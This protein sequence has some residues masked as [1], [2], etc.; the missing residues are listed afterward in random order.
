MDK[1]YYKDY[2]N[3][4]RKH[5]WFRARE[6]IIIDALKRKIDITKPLNILNVGCATGRSSEYLSVFGKVTSVEYDKDCC[7]FL[8]KET[9]IKPINASATA[10]P[11]IDE[12]FDLVCAFDVIEHIDEHQL[13]AKEICRVVKNNGYL[14]ITV[15]AYMSLW[16]KHDVINHHY[17]RYK[18]R[19]L[20]A[21]FKNIQN[22]HITHYTYFNTLFF[23]LIWLARKLS[24]II[25][26]N[27]KIATSDFNDPE[28]NKISDFVLYRI[29]LME[30]FLLRYFKFPFGVSAMLIAKKTN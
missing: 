23:P 30:K 27:Q 21:L 6:A 20:N 28:K 26:K 29:F 4:E 1:N 2:Y 5:W 7:D 22:I 17:R 16:S 24:N 11:F 3:L 12:E 8:L 19:E 18:M 15:P 25:F 14:F 13:A 9:T 10:L